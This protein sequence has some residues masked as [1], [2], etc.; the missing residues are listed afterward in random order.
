M[1]AFIKSSQRGSLLALA[2]I[3]TLIVS[4]SSVAMAADCVNCCPSSFVERTDCGYGG[5]T[6]EQCL[7]RKCCY[8][9]STTDPKI[10]HCFSQ[11]A[12]VRTCPTDKAART[13]CGFAG[14]TQEQCTQRKC[15]WDNSDARFPWCFSS[16]NICRP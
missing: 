2:A 13:D 14:I 5:I 3:V 16:Q 10:P 4:S 7:L 12:I 15:C 1:V 8:D 6:K 11:K 9:N